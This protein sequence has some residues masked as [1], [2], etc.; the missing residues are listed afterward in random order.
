M[1]IQDACVSYMPARRMRN[2]AE[3]ARPDDAERACLVPASTH[4][5]DPGFSKGTLRF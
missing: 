3:S 1:H 4:A 2:V 5:L